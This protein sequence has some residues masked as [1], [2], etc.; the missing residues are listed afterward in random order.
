MIARKGKATKAKEKKIRDTD[1]Y[2]LKARELSFLKLTILKEYKGIEG[3][4]IKRY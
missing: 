3:I 4:E 1:R 2:K